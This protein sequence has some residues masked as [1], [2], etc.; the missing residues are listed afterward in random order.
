[1][2][3]AKIVTDIGYSETKQKTL[4]DQGDRSCIWGQG[5]AANE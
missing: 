1:M 5:Y 2:Q 3:L 4:E